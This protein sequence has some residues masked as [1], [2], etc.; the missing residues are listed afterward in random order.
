MA[1]NVGPEF[2]RTECTTRDP[3]RH[4]GEPA[5]LVPDTPEARVR[6]TEP[7]FG[8]V[9]ETPAVS[10]IVSPDSAYISRPAEPDTT[11]VPNETSVYKTPAEVCQIEDRR[12]DTLRI[13]P[14]VRR[15]NRT[16]RESELVDSDDGEEAE[17][18]FPRRIAR[19]SERGK[20]RYRPNHEKVCK[21]LH[22]TRTEYSR[23]SSSSSDTE[24]EAAL[25][26]KPRV[27]KS[28]SAR[29]PKS[30]AKSDSTSSSSENGVHVRTTKPKHTLK[31]PKY[32]GT[33]SFKTFL[34]QFQ[35]CSVYNQW[36]ESTAGVFARVI[37]KRGWTS[38]LGL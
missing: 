22:W 9:M 17:N 19:S 12:Q 16:C 15:R 10:P 25:R 27:R 20:V 4:N 8:V 26:P 14:I 13:S 32:D 29:K 11:K 5:I 23:S 18:V 35:N 34:A 30:A 24:I 33:S 21:K 3:S 6:Q 7:L 2:G 1:P 37:R 28:S 36:T 31:P 38:P